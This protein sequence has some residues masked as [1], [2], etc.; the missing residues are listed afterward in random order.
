MITFIGTGLLGSNFVRSLIN[1][2]NS[3][4]VWNRTLTKAKALEVYGA[5]A[6]ENVADAVSGSEIIHLALKDD[7]VVND[8]L[9]IIAG[10]IQPGAILIDHTTTSVSGVLERTERLKS[11]GFN[12][13]HAP[14]FMGPQNALDSTGY[15]LVSGDQLL[16][17]QFQSYLDRMTGR[18]I[19][20]GTE[21]GKAAA[22][23]LAGNHF[24][25]TLTVSLMDT[26]SLS[27]GLNIED[28]ELIELLDI[29][30]PGGSIATRANRIVT[31]ND[32]QVSWE[33]R[34]ARKDISLMSEV[35][36]A[37][38]IKL[39]LIPPIAAKMDHFISNGYEDHDWMVIAKTDEI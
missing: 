27:K 16:I 32:S 21:T 9:D 31:R 3:V 38:N 1:H 23:K 37:K 33:L 17:K 22:M 25:V 13:L 36:T 7:Q 30:Y 10:S 28:K 4:K 20:L 5:V 34:M 24:I 15:M 11:L 6:Y 18:L 19:N 39:L 35:A 2:G 12:Y 29:F 26:L 8:I 14:V